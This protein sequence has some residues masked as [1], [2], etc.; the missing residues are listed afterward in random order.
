MVTEGRIWVP[1]TLE[2]LAPLPGKLGGGAGKDDGGDNRVASII[3]V[4]DGFDGPVPDT[5]AD[6]ELYVLPYTFDREPLARIAD[7]PRLR[8]IQTLTAGYE[9]VLPYL[10]PGVLLCNGRGIHETSTAELALTLTLA[11]L[12]D[13]PTFVRGQDAGEWRSGFYPA[14]ADKSVLIL[15]YGAIGEAVDRRLQGFEVDVVRVARSARAGAHGPVRAMA[16]LPELLPRA[17]VVIVTVPLSEDTRGLV[18]A[19]FLAR[20]PAG[21]L[22]VNVARGPVVDTDALLAELG[23]GRLRAALDV[24]DPEPLPAD[25]PLRFAPGTLIS[26]HVGG[27]SSAF[28]PRALRLIREQLERWSEGV[29]P[30]NVVRD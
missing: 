13:I 14:L 15:G 10:P 8:M 21:A 2:Q 12:R 9:H 19:D 23:A 6:V 29:T 7:M 28:L 25:H 17:D 24:T 11:A 26:P 16:E 22:V 4:Y 1:Y 30:A 3:D 27:S 18:D 20:L 5:A